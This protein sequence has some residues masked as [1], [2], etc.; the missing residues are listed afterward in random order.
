MFYIKTFGDSKAQLQT[1][2]KMLNKKNVIS[3]AVEFCRKKNDTSVLPP[4]WSVPPGV[5]CDGYRVVLWSFYSTYKNPNRC[6]HPG[7]YWSPLFEK[8]PE[9]PK[10]NHINLYVQKPYKPLFISSSNSKLLKKT[11]ER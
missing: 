10:D 4:Y 5:C 11:Y 3:G 1:R 6:A 7:E 8:C 9:R 2:G